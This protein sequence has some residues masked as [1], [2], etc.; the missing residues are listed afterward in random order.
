MAY[1]PSGKDVARS[2][3]DLILRGRE[4]ADS[5]Y[6]GRLTGQELRLL[7]AVYMKRASDCLLEPG[8]KLDRNT[9]WEEVRRAVSFDDGLLEG[10]KEVDAKIDQMSEVELDAWERG[11]WN[12]D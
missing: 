9:S 12:E 8:F 4:L 3:T 10:L 7:T 2:V 1:E 5:D 6:R 11:G